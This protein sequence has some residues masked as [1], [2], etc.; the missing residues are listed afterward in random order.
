MKVTLSNVGR[1]TPYTYRGLQRSKGTKIEIV[2]P[3]AHGDHGQRDKTTSSRVAPQL[4]LDRMT[5][6]TLRG[7]CR[8]CGSEKVSL[9]A[10]GIADVAGMGR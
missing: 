1:I 6:M 9:S 7:G 5:R 10:C 3:R 4:F 8:N 2:K